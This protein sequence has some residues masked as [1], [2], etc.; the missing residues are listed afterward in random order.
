MCQC[1]RLH[2]ANVAELYEEHLTLSFG[3]VMRI[4]LAVLSSLMSLLPNG[5]FYSHQRLTVAKYTFE[6]VLAYCKKSAAR[7]NFANIKDAT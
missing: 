1:L 5:I 7:S 2:T 6:F 4:E 3:R